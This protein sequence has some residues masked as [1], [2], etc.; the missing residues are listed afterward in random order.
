MSRLLKAQ[1]IQKVSCDITEA[2]SVDAHLMTSAHPM[3]DPNV[4]NVAI[5]PSV[6]ILSKVQLE[7]IH[8]LNCE[9]KWKTFMA[10][11]QK[12]GTSHNPTPV[13]AVILEN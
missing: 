11:C 6:V 13:V 10:V 5:V 9:V 1:T 3:E 7:E 2:V 4:K 8:T 12:K